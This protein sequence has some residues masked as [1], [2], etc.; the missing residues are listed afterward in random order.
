MP[1]DENDNDK[2]MLTELIE[3]GRLNEEQE[4]AFTSMLE[5]LEAGKRGSLTGRQRD[6]VAG[7]HGRF[8]LDPGTA[9]LVSSGQVK[10]TAQE[11][12]SLNQFLTHL[13]P[14]PLKPPGRK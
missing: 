7:V 2:R 6:W 14:K 13:G 8:G 10:V 3:S 4:K 1:P 11:R 12:K 9:N 5:E